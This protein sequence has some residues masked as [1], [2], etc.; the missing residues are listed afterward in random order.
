MNLQR[1]LGFRP[2]GTTLPARLA[3]YQNRKYQ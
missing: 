1:L 2:K 3:T